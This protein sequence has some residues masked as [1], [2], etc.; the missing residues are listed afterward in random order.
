MKSGRIRRTLLNRAGDAAVG[1]TNYLYF[2]I[3]Y[4]Y[5]AIEAASE[6]GGRRWKKKGKACKERRRGK[7]ETLPCEKDRWSEYVKGTERRE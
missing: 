2:F 6:R 3:S 1:T 4:E 5:N 7:K